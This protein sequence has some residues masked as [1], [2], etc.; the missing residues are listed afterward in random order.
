MIRRIDKHTAAQLSM[1][2]DRPIAHFDLFPE[3]RST[4]FNHEV[5]QKSIH[6]NMQSLDAEMDA[7]PRF[8]RWSHKLKLWRRPQHHGTSNGNCEYFMGLETARV[9]KEA[10][11]L[12]KRIKDKIHHIKAEKHE[13]RRGLWLAAT[14][15]TI[16]VDRFRVTASSGGLGKGRGKGGK[17]SAEAAA[18]AHASARR[19]VNEMDRAL[20]QGQTSVHESVEGGQVL[21]AELEHAEHSLMESMEHLLQEAKE[22]AA[23]KQAEH[24]VE[25]SIVVATRRALRG[26]SDVSSSPSPYAATPG[27]S[28]MCQ[29]SHSVQHT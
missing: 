8:L 10:R 15:E 16:E 14:R 18:T 20:R 29:M 22:E 1:R 11:V 23:A 21:D 2:L 17:I 4:S 28:P 26:V 6:D 24:Q 7:L 3:A 9:E 25:S 19:V 5:T 13:N 12:R 27:G